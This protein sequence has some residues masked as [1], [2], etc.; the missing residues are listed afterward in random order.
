MYLSYFFDVF[1]VGGTRAPRL[2]TLT[3]VQRNGAMSEPQKI[4]LTVLQQ[5]NPA[6]LDAPLTLP[7]EPLLPSNVPV[8]DHAALRPDPQRAL[9]TTS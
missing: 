9:R 3:R 7:D 8:F 1:A 2:L 4:R 5:H 6:V